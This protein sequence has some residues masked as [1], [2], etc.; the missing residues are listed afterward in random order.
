M[1]FSAP[2]MIFLLDGGGVI[3]Q[4]IGCGI[5]SSRYDNSN[6]CCSKKGF[7]YQWCWHHESSLLSERRGVST[8]YLLS[9]IF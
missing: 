4:L 7:F 2:G 1:G 5:L 9:R 8:F 3:I 6:G